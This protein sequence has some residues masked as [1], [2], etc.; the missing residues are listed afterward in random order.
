MNQVEALSLMELLSIVIATALGVLSATTGTKT[1]EGKLTKW[2][3][4]ALAGIIITNAFSFS[5]SFLKQKQDQINKIQALEEGRKKDSL[6]RA[7]YSNQI[8]LL[9]ENIN[10]SDSSLKQQFRIQQQTQNVLGGIGQSIL[11][12]KN[13]INQSELLN[14]QQQHSLKEIHRS[15]NPLLPFR[16][17]K[18]QF[19]LK[20]SDEL[21]K[22][23]PMLNDLNNDIFEAL[24]KEALKKESGLKQTA[25]SDTLVY[26]NKSNKNF[27]K[28]LDLIRRLDIFFTFRKDNADKLKIQYLHFN[29]L[30][31]FINSNSLS[32]NVVIF[33]RP[34]DSLTTFSL[35]EVPIDITAGNEMVSIDDLDDTKFQMFIHALPGAVTTSFISLSLPP[36]FS[37]VKKVQGGSDYCSTSAG[38]RYYFYSYE[39]LFKLEYP[40][41]QI[42]YIPIP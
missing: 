39:A 8:S 1:R 29:P 2:G 41:E 17:A 33:F 9:F 10:K 21:S 24:A 11:M 14:V 23:N 15:L 6:E 31:E 32:N 5:R 13:I 22:V 20:Q 37:T 4:I 42:F 27:N 34:A 12:Q 28:Y 18:L 16:I 36:N 19:T 38:D 26:I 30:R 3:I 40:A 7:N 25:F 35:N